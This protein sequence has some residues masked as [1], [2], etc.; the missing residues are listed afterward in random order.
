MLTFAVYYYTSTR[1]FLKNKYI[2]DM[3]KID[4]V[5]F[6][7]RRKG[8]LVLEGIDLTVRP[9]GVY[10]LLGSN[11]VG[12]STLL[13]L[14]AGALTPRTGEVR[15]DGVNTRLRQPSTMAEIF[16]VPEEIELPKIKLSSYVKANSQFY[17]RFSHEQM[18]KYLDNFGLETDLH[19]G[20]LSMGQRKKAFISFALACN[21]SLLLMDEP[22]NGLDIP[23]KGAFRRTIASEMND[24][25]TMII[26]THQVRDID[27][28]LDHVIIMDH[29]RVLLDASIG[30]IMDKLNF[31]VTSDRALIDSALY[32]QPSVEGTMVVVPNVTGELTD[33]NL[34]SLFELAIAKPGYVAELFNAKNQDEV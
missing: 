15:F 3:L 18:L 25:R 8:R 14:I 27:R 23:G 12:K 30:S 5:S 21:T 1:V 10:G 22:T 34:E 28:L 11:G 16:I 20:E 7:Y 4:N 19:L 6:S 29:S 31:V 24:D 17:P 33:V 13:Y 2:F 26:S 32:S 9:G